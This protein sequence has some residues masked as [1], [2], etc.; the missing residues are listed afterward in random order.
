M[1]LLFPM[2]N[3]RNN[4]I[5]VLNGPNLN[6]LGIREPHIYGYE[7]LADVQKI[8]EDTAKPLG[9]LIDFRQSNHE[10]ELVT[11]IQE[12]RLNIAGLIINAAA[13]THTSVAI[14]DALKLMDVPIVELHVS[15]PTTREA[16]RHFSYISLLAT[17]VIKGKGAAGYAEAVLSLSTLVNG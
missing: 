6:M 2:N 16:F 7:T 10:G 3:Q 8:C 17:N 14:Y 13:Y 11:W 12:E 15:D 9:L 4:K 1:R 5:L